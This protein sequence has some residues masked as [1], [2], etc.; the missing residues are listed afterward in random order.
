MLTVDFELLRRRVPLGGEILMRTR[1]R[2][3]ADTA[4]EVASLYDNNQITNY[5]ILDGM[6]NLL[7]TVNH[8]TRQ[9][10][11]GRGEPRTGDF[12]LITL[13]AGGEEAREDNL[14]RY[15]WFEHPGSYFVRALYRWEEHEVWS[16]PQQLE[17][18]P[19]PL[20]AYD[21]QWVYHYA[22]KFHL[23]STWVAE[24]SDGKLEL[25]LRESLRSR[26]TVIN[27]NRSLGLVSAPIQPR[28]SFDRSLMAGGSVWLSWLGEG[29]VTVLKTMAGQA[30]GGPREHVLGLH[31]LDW[32]AAPIASGADDDMTMFLCAARPDGGRLVTALRVGP[33]GGESQR[34]VITEQ[35][36][37]VVV[38][39]GVCDEEGVFHLLWLTGD[40]H[41]L[42]HQPISLS[43]LQVLAKP[44]RLWQVA[45]LPLAIL[46]APVWTGES[47]LACLYASGAGKDQPT[48]GMAWLQL[49]ERRN[50]RKLE[51]LVVPGL[52]S[53]VRCAGETT[54]SGR[55]FA[56]L[57][58]R[59]AVLYVD[60]ALAQS[61][62]VAS[63]EDFQPRGSEQLTVNNKNDVFLVASRVGLGLS[64]TF[65]RSGLD[66][67]LSEEGLP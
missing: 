22:E 38:M 14:C 55:L 7:K 53:L 54:D 36:L 19:A 16:A 12:R 23:Q 4:I 41:E 11:M 10:L 5:A 18:V 52:E 27:H 43:T 37:G 15:E 57:T 51:T 48:L 28:L 3:T 34:A 1:L 50:P 21:Q 44:T 32:V 29:R 9:L 2:N 35:L 63:T 30:V 40:T 49:D 66:E 17:I 42:W 8:V 6:G 24:L 33:D 62:Q 26:P 45:G 25:F 13:S 65:I 31:D 60:G 61:R 67:D 59:Q 39:H 58:T 46:S 47:Y 56:L 20:H 64:E